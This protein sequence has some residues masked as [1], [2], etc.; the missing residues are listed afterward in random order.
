MASSP[1]IQKT[2]AKTVLVY[3]SDWKEGGAIRNCLEACGYVATTWGSF[4]DATRALSSHPWTMVVISTNLGD[5]FD[6]FLKELR[7]M[8]QPPKVI[9]IADEDEGDPSARCFLQFVAVLNRPF[10]FSDLADLAE[11]L[12]G[13][14]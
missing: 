13:K 3:T 8:K 6:K 1:T 11:H 2:V 12:I 5:N 10:K 14:A 4:E 9:L 7:P